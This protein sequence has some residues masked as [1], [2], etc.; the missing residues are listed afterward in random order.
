MSQS[1]YYQKLAR[2]ENV[3]KALQEMSSQ[4]QRAHKFAIKQAMA[5]RQLQDD[6]R[7]TRREIDQLSNWTSDRNTTYWTIQIAVR[8]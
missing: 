5:E 8:S 7:A 2:Q 4:H 1:Q 6:I 3:R